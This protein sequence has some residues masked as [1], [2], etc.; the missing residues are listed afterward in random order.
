[1]IHNFI[2]DHKAREKF[3]LN[4]SVGGKRDLQVQSRYMI[5]VILDDF[6]IIFDMNPIHMIK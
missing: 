5:I 2:V 3:K 6:K 1:M 4:E